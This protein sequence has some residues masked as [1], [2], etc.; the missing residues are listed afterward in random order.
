M[1]TLTT[2]QSDITRLDPSVTPCFW[3]EIVTAAWT[4]FA[5]KNNKQGKGGEKKLL[6]F[7]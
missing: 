5:C 2:V 6:F 3:R 1:K 7:L 4:F